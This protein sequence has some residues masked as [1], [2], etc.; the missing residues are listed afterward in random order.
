MVTN[1][2]ILLTNEVPFIDELEWEGLQKKYKI[3][4]HVPFTSEKLPLGSKKIEIFRDDEYKIKGKLRGDLENIDELKLLNYD[5]EKIIENNEKILAISESAIHT[6]YEIKCSFNKVSYGHNRDNGNYFKSDMDISY[7]KRTFK[8]LYEHLKEYSDVYWFTEW[9]LN[10]PIFLR[11]G[12]SI[13]YSLCKKYNRRMKEPQYPI[14]GPNHKLHKDFYFNLENGIEQKYYRQGSYSKPYMFVE[15]KDENDEDKYFT[16]QSVPDNYGPSWSNK[17][18]IEYRTEWGLPTIEER[19]KLNEIISFSIGRQLISI[20]YTK[21]NKKGLI[22]EDCCYTPYISEG[23][24]FHDLCKAKDMTPINQIDGNIWTDNI[25]THLKRLIPNYIKLR[26]EL[27]LHEV[28]EKYWL[29]QSIPKEA[30]II[31]L[32]ASLESLIKSWYKSKKSKSKGVYLPKDDFEDDL[33]EGL[34][35]IENK[36]NN[37]DFGEN[38]NFKDRILRKIQNSYNMSLNER[39]DFF[40]KE[41][42]LNV[43]KIEKKAIQ[44]RN[45][46]VH[47]DILIQGN[48]LKTNEFDEMLRMTNAYRT[49]LNRIILKILNYDKEYID[50]YRESCPFNTIRDIIRPIDEP[51]THLENVDPELSKKRRVHYF[52]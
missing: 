34:E 7:V 17:V 43:G 46:P 23:I 48:I 49:L 32:A 1:D 26:D 16:V 19:K 38:T 2:D 9:F 37:R 33:R 15:F 18:S 13:D 42:G 4:E 5:R 41:I 29:A 31:I 21:Y 27:K 30:E 6:E 3:G 22:L 28:L 52:P 10:G 45:K 50:F 8:P 35:L 24:H 40:F 14:I 47:G 39:I 51:V 36:L 11:Y 25:G 20:G 44:Y 12:G